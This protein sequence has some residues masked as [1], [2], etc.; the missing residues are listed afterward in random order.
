MTTSAATVSLPARRGLAG[1]LQ[2]CAVG[3][4]IDNLFRQV[5]V[6]ALG[7]V[8]FAAF[9]N[10]E[11]AAGE[12]SASY[13][14]WALMLFSL[15]FI[16]LAPLAGSLG[17]RL[18]KHHI[19]RA[20]RIVDVPIAVLGIWGYAAG[21]PALM[22]SALTLLAIAST[23][24]APVKLAVMPEL[25]PPE[26]LSSGNAILAAVTVLA[27]LG[28]TCL[29]AVTDR[30]LLAQVFGVHAE[31][32]PLIALSAVCAVLLV[33]GIVGAFKIPPLPAQAPGRP[34]AM[35]WM[36][37]EQVR[38]LH[39]APGVWA[40]A[41][42]LAGFW[43]LGGAAFAGLP[44]VAKQVYGLHEAGVVSLFLA[45]VVGIVVGS[46]L[47]PRLLAR[48]FPAGLPVNGA[49]L[50]G[51][52][53]AA[54]GLVAVLDGHVV[55]AERHRWLFSACLFATGIGAGLWEVP[56]TILLQERAPATSRN[57]IMSGVSVLGSFGTFAAAG[58]FKVLTGV[59]G[60]TPSAAFVAS[61]LFAAG[62]ASICLVAYRLQIAGW[63]VATLTRLAFRIRV[64]GAEHLPTA[65]GCLVVCNHLSY[66]D[67]VVLGASLPR[68]ARFLVY[69]AYVEMPVVGFFLRAAGVIPVAAEDRRRALLASIDTAIEAAKAGEVVVIFPE[70][71]LT[72]SGQTNTF[73]SGMERIAA[74]AGVPVVPAHLAGLWGT[75]TSRA[76]QRRWPRL[77]RPIDLRLG[78]PLPS[79]T[80]AAIARDHVMR[81]GYEAAQAH[82]DR[83]PRSLASAFLRH[84][85]RHPRRTAV[86]D[87]G[88][89]ISYFGIAAA[90]RAL[91]PRLG[92]AADEARVGVLLPPGRG[93]AIVNLALALLGR[94]AVNLNHT[95]GNAQLAR[96]CEMAQV[97]TVISSAL[98][99]RRLSGTEVPGRRVLVE[100]LLPGIGKAGLLAAG[101]GALLLPRRLVARARPGDVAAIVFSSGST[102]DPKGVELTHRQLISNCDAV[103]TGLDIDGAHD[104]LLS[105]LPLFHS[106]GLVHGLWV[107]LSQGLP[108]ANQPDPTDGKALG[109]L[110]QKSR[111]TIMLSTPTFVRGYLRRI[112]P[113]QLRTLKFAVVGA[114]RCPAELRA[115][116]RER[117]KAELFE[118][119]GC[120]ELAPAVA[121]NLPT[122]KRDGVTEVRSRDG[123]VGRA[124]PGIQAFASDPVDGHAL[125]PGSE[126]LLVVRSP[127]RMRGYLDRP[128]LTGKAFT[129]GGYNTGDI[130][131]VDAEGFIFITGRL[132]RFAKIGG[133]MVPLDNVERILQEALTAAAGAEPTLEL[134]VAAVPD[135]GRGERLVVLH[136]GFA[137]DWE[138]L[139]KALDGNPALWRP[140][141]RDVR[142]VATI[143]K[144][145]TGKRDLAAL[146]KLA[147]EGGA[148]KPVEIAEGT[149]KPESAGTA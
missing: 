19:I 141:S 12:L 85:R 46:A 11:K 30:D 115:Q 72:R 105:P 100:E 93:G 130:G 41:L 3:A 31:S 65:G 70:G 126:G 122:V 44:T 37:V 114:E 96:M 117:F 34:I 42:G 92:L 107:G 80:T 108:L 90:A 64:T 49:L 91:A 124:L 38:S 69:R 119:Y 83:D 24:F 127:G 40:P 17:D 53:F 139:F 28:G 47:A 82:A 148:A 94:T 132:A 1:H 121:F 59:A 33:V 133:E 125:P 88:G 118:G 76:P 14:S 101:L 58:S 23:F 66:S 123:S 56:L 143:P 51:L 75:I 25:V 45:L 110:A 145:G 135:E 109:E 95:A 21:S 27:I 86:Q 128:D 62:V 120:T 50:A 129:A 77:R 140:K 9:P 73:H 2:A 99:L 29:G 74:R 144:L 32:A 48:L 63:V 98:Y 43:G 84:L 146:K 137:G 131:R 39:R 57:L 71:Q 142:Q 103:I 68:R 89:S 111:A 55:A 97:R 36:V 20:A 87:A 104:V 67:G 5:A 7:A 15:P 35:P 54:A 106:F 16:V 112:E 26:R 81:L 138:A 147:L 116:F 134:A 136:T 13:A 79:D 52:A 18:P 4:G 10:D 78:A 22:L 61:G 8:A 149:A 102:G 60:L 113:E 6:V